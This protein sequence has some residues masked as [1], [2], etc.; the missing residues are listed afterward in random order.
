M[1][2]YDRGDE[3]FISRD[4]GYLVS[5]L[6]QSYAYRN[7]LFLRLLYSLITVETCLL[8]QC[9]QSSYLGNSNAHCREID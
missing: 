5:Q 3:K 1:V 8:G 2:F 7:D 9:D 4:L 6:N